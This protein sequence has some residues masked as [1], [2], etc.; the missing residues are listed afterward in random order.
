MRSTG[1]SIRNSPSVPATS[2]SDQMETVTGSGFN[3]VVLEGKGPIAVE[4]MSYG[5]P[6]CRTIEPVLQRVAEMVKANEKIVRVDVAVDQ[7]LA[8]D[9][10][11]EGTPSLVM[12]LNGRQV[13]RI[14]GPSPTIAP[15]QTKRRIRLRSRRSGLNDTRP[16][17]HFISKRVDANNRPHHQHK[18]S[19]DSCSE[20]SKASIATNSPH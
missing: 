15:F 18:T 3:A 8:S 17:K 1:Q 9:Y 7:E 19:K 11:I 13:G 12:F 2:L 4:F 5:C 20:I 10:N 16:R 14:E 6:H